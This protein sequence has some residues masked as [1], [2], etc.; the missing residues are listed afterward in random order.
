MS[1]KT[2]PRER[3]SVIMK[4]GMVVCCAVML[5]PVFGYFAAGGALA[6]LWSNAAVFAPLAI[7]LG[8]HLVMHRMMGRSCRSKAVVEERSSRSMGRAAGALFA[9]QV[10]VAR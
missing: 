3:G 7:C 1:E 9:R 5:V 4:V 2:Q 6:G 8:A 10:E